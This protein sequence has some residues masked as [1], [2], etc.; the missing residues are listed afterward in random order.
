MSRRLLHILRESTL[1]QQANSTPV[2]LPDQL[3]VQLRER[4]FRSGETF[5]GIVIQFVEAYLRQQQTAAVFLGQGQQAPIPET[6][7]EI[8]HRQPLAADRKKTSIAFSASLA[9]L[10][11]RKGIT[12][13]LDF[14]SAIEEACRQWVRR[15]TGAPA[16]STKHSE[17][18]STKAAAPTTHSF[19][20][21]WLLQKITIIHERDPDLGRALNTLIEA[22][23]RDRSNYAP[24]DTDACPE[25]QQ[26]DDLHAR[27]DQIEGDTNRDAAGRRARDTPA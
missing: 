25:T 3:K 17:P 21:A 1:S 24:A 4:L 11:K 9:K 18:A 10:V 23:S 7:I 12:C 22:I 26:P 6:T 5:Q 8:D 27:L 2:R 13:D 16:A 14:S 20:P 19:Q 15:P